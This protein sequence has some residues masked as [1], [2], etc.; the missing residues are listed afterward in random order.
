M[1]DAGTSFCPRCGDPIAED[2]DG[3][4]RRERSLCDAC[5]F[6][7]FDLVDAPD[8][9][10]VRVCAR[11]GA[12]YRGNRWVDVG[13]MDYTDV[14]IEETSEALGVHV[15]AEDVEWEVR[16]EQLDEN[17]IRMHCFFS[18]TVRG[19]VQ[20]EEVVVPVKVSR[21]T[22][23]RCGRIAGDYY[24]STVQVRANGRD[25]TSEETDRAEELAHS[26]VADMESTGDRNAFVTEITD[27]E[28]GIDIKLST[29]KIG[30]KLSR[31][32]VEE[33]GGG[34]EDHETLVTEDEDGNEVYRV[35]YAVRF[36]EFKPGDVID[37][38]DD[39]GGPVLVRSVRGNLKGVRVTTGEPYEASYEDGDSPEARKLGAREDAAE[40][41]VVTV[42]D[43]NSVQILDP[44]TFESKTV[45]RPDYV[46]EDASTV[47]ALKSRA[48]LHVLPEA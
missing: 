14:A 12:V 41:T 32:L 45:P 20:T 18:G 24:A 44:E 4:T 6:S 11:C 29:N 26:I 43:D 17:S 27:A 33:F 48:G 2:G 10:E 1:T 38:A 7:D 35:T 31:K 40:A 16:P 3:A 28:S 9:I 37:L 22:C 46:D 21:Q 39:D 36:P 19:T 42:E 25:P 23:T 47:P 15:E 30:L 8:R 34:F 5:Y 13:A